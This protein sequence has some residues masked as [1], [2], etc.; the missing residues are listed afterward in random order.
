M[1]GN[2]WF[3]RESG[4]KTYNIEDPDYP[5]LPSRENI[6]KGAQLDPAQKAARTDGRSPLAIQGTTFSDELAVH[7]AGHAKIFAVS[8]KDRGA[9]PLAGHSGK[10]FWYSVDTG[11]FITSRF[12][13]DQNPDFL[14][15]W[16]R[17]RLAEQAAGTSWELLNPLD[18]YLLKDHDDRPYETDL[19]GYG[20]VFPH[21]FGPVD[22]PLFATRLLVSPVGDRLTADLAMHI[23]QT[24]ELGNDPV[25][26]FL[27]V[28]FSGVDAVNHFFGPS[29]LENEDVLLQLDRTLAG[30]LAAVDKQVGLDKTLVVLAADHGMAEMPE[31]MAELGHDV[32]RLH[33]EEVTAIAAAAAERQF[34]VKGL[35][36]LF[37][38]PYL[39]LDAKVLKEAD[40]DRATVAEALAEELA[41]VKGIALAVPYTQQR[42]LWASG[43]M[44]R[45]QRN[46]HPERSG[47]IYLAQNPYWFL[48]EKGAIAVMHGSPWSYDTH[49][50]ILFS[51]PGILPRRV[52]RLV[53]PVDVSPT[54]SA[55]LGVKPPAGARGN[56]LQEVV[57]R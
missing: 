23:L 42:N 51:G 32:G 13:Y 35:V 4:E 3:D 24:Q 27:S 57:D 10:A 33:T 40:L 20:R 15:E 26:D 55:Y 47:D 34:G 41:L 21:P 9:V 19:K 16:N 25:T 29:S 28:S 44:G 38:R 31:A 45:V 1:V 39:Y 11:D 12:Y 17:R 22:H 48:Y 7:T 37:Y 52:S 6:T 56:P 46:Y 8:G 50:P 36:S 2:L 43:P 5:L 30:L 18:T 53:H 14:V 49:V 54:L